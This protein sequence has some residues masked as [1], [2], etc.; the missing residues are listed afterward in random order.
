MIGGLGDQIPDL[1]RA[2][3]DRLLGAVLANLRAGR[4][5]HAAPDAWRRAVGVVEA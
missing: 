3:G 2:P 4:T 5:R 1:V